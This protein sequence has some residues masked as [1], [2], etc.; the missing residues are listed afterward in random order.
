MRMMIK[1][2]MLPCVVSL[3]AVP[4][5]AA[6]ENP[7]ASLRA[8]RAL[9]EDAKRLA[10]YDREIDRLGEQA[11]PAGAAAAA[12]ALT[13]EERFGRTGPMNREDAD[14]KAQES[15]ELG[16]L[17]ATVAEIWTRAD[18]LMV[19]TLDNGQIWK[20]VRPD[21]QFRLKTGEKVRIQP[22][23]LGSYLLSGESKRST[24][25]SRVK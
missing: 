5:M 3:M 14:R 17:R 2:M 19:L 18:G 25:V 22:A 10:C 1:G 21:S 20:Q 7:D 11:V 4:A 8:C 16:E 9:P 6:A 12:P 15:R 23:A 13:P 24:R